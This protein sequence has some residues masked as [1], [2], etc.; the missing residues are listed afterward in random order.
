VELS[1]AAR[2]DQKGRTIVEVTGDLTA[3]SAAQLHE[4][5]VRIIVANSFF[6]VI[7]LTGVEALDPDAAIPIL[8]DAARRVEP[9]RGWVRVVDK[10]DK[11]A[12]HDVRTLATHDTNRPLR[13]FPTLETALHG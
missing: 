5:L 10:S 6:L 9:Y 13:V 3:Q 1:V 4:N 7:D 12:S 11:L 8:E 2:E